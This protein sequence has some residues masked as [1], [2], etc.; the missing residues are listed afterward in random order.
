MLHYCSQLLAILRFFKKLTHSEA[1]TFRLELLPK[2]FSITI[3]H[4]LTMTD[5]N[6]L[7]TKKEQLKLTSLFVMLMKKKCVLTCCAFNK[8]T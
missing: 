8:G 7:S 2:P 1:C 4:A 6:N 3:E 5:N